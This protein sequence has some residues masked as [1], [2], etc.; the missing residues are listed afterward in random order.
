MKKFPMESVNAK[1]KLI[2]DYLQDKII[3][4]YQSQI[5]M[6]TMYNR[7]IRYGTDDNGEVITIY[8]DYLQTQVDAIYKNID[9]YKRIHYPGLF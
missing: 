9:D 7:D 6:L 1:Q 2:E 3:N 5:V 4:M 8:P